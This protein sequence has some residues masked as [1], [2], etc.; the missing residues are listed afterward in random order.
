MFTDDQLKL[1]CID[2]FKA[3]GYQYA[4]GYDIAPDGKSPERDDYRQ[5]ILK[6]RFLRHWKYPSDKADGT[7]KLILDPVEVLA[8]SCS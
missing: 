4:N 3:Q 2:C 7:I 5:V 8:D 1:L 6:T